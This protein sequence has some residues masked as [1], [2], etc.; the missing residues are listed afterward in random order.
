MSSQEFKL[1]GEA[2]YTGTINDRRKAFFLNA[3]FDNEYQFLVGKGYSGTL[4]DMRYQFAIDKGVNLSQ[5]VRDG[6]YGFYGGGDIEVLGYAIG[7]AVDLFTAAT[8]D[9]SSLSLEEGDL[10]LALS[11]RTDQGVTFAP[12]PATSG[13]TEVATPLYADSTWDVYASIHYKFMG[14]TPDTELVMTNDAQQGTQVVAIAIRGANATTPIA[15]ALEASGSNVHANP[16]AI[17]PT[18]GN[19]VITYGAGVHLGGAIAYTSG[20]VPNFFS[21]GLATSSEDPVF[22]FGYEI[23]DGSALDY[24]AF[25]H[26]QDNAGFSWVGRSIEIAVA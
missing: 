15:Q 20:T 18:D 6:A 8:A 17:T 11:A 7:E 26:T 12:A 16:P 21:Q 19:L 14:A 5:F 4:N 10:I 1:L 25:S 23:S 9:F 24:A 13:Y 3:G 2:G 22:G